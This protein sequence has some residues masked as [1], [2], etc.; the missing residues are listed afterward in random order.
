MLA[1]TLLI[2]FS[3]VVP[4]ISKFNL[5]SPI[6]DQYQWHPDSK[7]IYLMARVLPQS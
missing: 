7:D 6:L 2:L 4:K 5:V 1:Y 3:M